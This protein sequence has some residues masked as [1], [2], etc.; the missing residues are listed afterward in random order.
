MLYTLLLWTGSHCRPDPPDR[1]PGTLLGRI[2]VC[3]SSLTTP[4]LPA[5]MSKLALCFLTFFA[6]T[7]LFPLHEMPFIP[8]PPVEILPSSSNSW[9][10]YFTTH[11]WVLSPEKS[12][13]FFDYTPPSTFACTIVIVVTVCLIIEICILVPS[14]PTR[15][16]TP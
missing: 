14:F 16:K 15:L 5:P 1:M 8:L 3:I 12:D 7:N 2:P 13:L 10:T 9:G 6:F 11:N 4:P